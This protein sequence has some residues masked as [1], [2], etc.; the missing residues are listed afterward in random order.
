MVTVVDK[1]KFTGWH[2]GDMEKL[3]A[4]AYSLELEARREDVVFLIAH[5]LGVPA[6]GSK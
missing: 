6:C 1:D 3:A 4:P 5:G 2:K